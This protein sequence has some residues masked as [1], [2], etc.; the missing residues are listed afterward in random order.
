MLSVNPAAYSLK[1]KK[2]VR[3]GSLFLCL[4]FVLSIQQFLL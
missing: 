2:A 1:S 4:K 3:K